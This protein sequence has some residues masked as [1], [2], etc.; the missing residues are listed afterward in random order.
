ME[1]IVEFWIVDTI[2]IM[3]REKFLAKLKLSQWISLPGSLLMIM[4]EL[5]HYR[6][7]VTSSQNFV[8][9]HSVSDV[10]LF[11]IQWYLGLSVFILAV[12]IFMPARKQSDDEE[13]EVE[14]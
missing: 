10:F 5:I 6:P 9:F 14:E 12:M 13:N 8:E 2:E 7:R 11:W 4:A 1:F 3:K